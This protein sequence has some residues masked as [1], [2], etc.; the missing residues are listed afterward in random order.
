MEIKIYDTVIV[1]G[2]P[3]GLTAALYLARANKKVIVIEKKGFGSLAAAHKI[4]N[5]P[6]FEDGITG[7]ELLGKMKKQAVKFGAEIS[8]DIFLDLDSMSNP[9]AVKCMNKKYI[10]K[11]VIISTGIWKGNSHKF[12][13]ESEFLGKGVSYCATCDGAF[14][15]NMTVAVLGNG[16]EACEEAIY[17]TNHAAKVLIFVKENILTCEENTKQ[18]IKDNPKI[19]VVYERELVEIAGSEFVEKIIVKKTNNGISEEYSSDA[20]FMYLGTKSNIEMFANFAN[21]N[22]KGMIIT[23][24]K[25]ESYVE[26]VY[27]AGDIREKSVRQITTAVSDGT[28]A[29]SEVIKFL[30]KK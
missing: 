18:S 28:I 15:K 4:E 26:G 3:A 30:M 22:E 19:E 5:Y 16:E 7:E 11:S 13:G 1:G 25:L 29:A 23:N 20:A 17:L 6:G 2:G 27:I 14:Y 10:G 9:I 21:I 12:K 8:E 24:D